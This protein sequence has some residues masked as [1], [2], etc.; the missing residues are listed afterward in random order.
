MYNRGELSAKWMGT[1]GFKVKVV[2][3][4]FIVVR[5]L[6]RQNLKSCDVTMFFLF[7]EYG[8]EVH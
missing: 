1:N 4:W 3:E 2:N 8:K 7:V 6:C 5:S